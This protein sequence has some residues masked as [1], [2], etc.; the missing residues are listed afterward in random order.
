M[1]T[2]HGAL[3]F[4]KEKSHVTAESILLGLKTSGLP[5]QELNEK[6]QSI[7]LSFCLQQCSFSSLKCFL[8]D[9]LGVSS[10]SQ[11]KTFPGSYITGCLQVGSTAGKG[12][13]TV[14]LDLA[15]KHTESPVLQ[16]LHFGLL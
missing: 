2:Y 12:N 15:P 6:G 7:L 9:T 3:I 13:A 8:M 10:T 1:K 5:Q 4:T 14:S 16:A 11:N